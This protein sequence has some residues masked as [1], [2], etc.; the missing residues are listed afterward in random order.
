[1]INILGLDL[2]MKVVD[3]FGC[4]VPVLAK[5]FNCIDELVRDG[6]NGFLFDHASDLSDRFVSLFAGFPLHSNVILFISN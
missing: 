6:E 3:M 4:G 1:M 2:P 5:R